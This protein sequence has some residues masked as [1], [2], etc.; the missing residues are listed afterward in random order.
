MTPF[1][2]TSGQF[3]SQVI[4]NEIFGCSPVNFNEVYSSVFT[5]ILSILEMKIFKILCDEVSEYPT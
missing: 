4:E 5:T 3:S 2:K 1:G